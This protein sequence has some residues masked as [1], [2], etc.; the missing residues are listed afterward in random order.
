MHRDA[1]VRTSRIDVRPPTQPLAEAI[2][3]R[4]LHLEGHESRVGVLR[5]AQRGIHGERALRG[6]VVFPGYRVRCVIQALRSARFEL[7][8]RTKHPHRDAAPEAYPQSFAPIR[9][10]PDAPAILP[11]L[12]R[13]E[14]GQLLCQE[15]LRSAGSSRVKLQSLWHARTLSAHA[16]RSYPG[17]APAPGSS[18]AGRISTSRGFAPSAGPTSPSRSMRSI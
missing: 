7:S 4:I 2:G 12:L 16:A 15:R 9:G 8:K 10:E 1:H 13:A 6:Q 18:P 5:I 11:N 3:N 17:I 14:I